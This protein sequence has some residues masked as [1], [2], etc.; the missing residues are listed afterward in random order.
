V[1]FC[2][3]FRKS[4][5]KLEQVKVTEEMH[6][7]AINMRYLGTIVKCLAPLGPK[8]RD[9]A[10]LLVIEASARA[11]KNELRKRLRA[12]MKQLKVPLEVPYKRVV[13]NYFNMVFGDHDS[14]TK[15][16]STSLMELLC[17]HFE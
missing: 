16:W 10:R 9:T 4:L 6:R 17:V 1:F 7:R 13:L 15:Y 14:S 2:F 5:G 12:K 8:A 11:L 3:F